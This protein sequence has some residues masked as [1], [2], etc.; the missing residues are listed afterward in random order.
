GRLHGAGL[1][2]RHGGHGYGRLRPGMG[3]RARRVQ[4]RGFRPPRRRGPDRGPGGRGR[5]RRNPAHAPRRRLMASDDL[6]LEEFA[7]GTALTT[8]D[9]MGDKTATDLAPVF[10]VPVNISAVLG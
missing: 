1:V 5:A 4:P 6:A 2:P 10:D 8:S 3:G 7:E 9:E